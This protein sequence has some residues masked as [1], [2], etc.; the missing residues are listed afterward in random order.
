MSVKRVACALISALLCGCFSA[1]GAGEEAPD[2]SVS[3]TVTEPAPA[4]EAAVYLDGKNGNDEN[5][6]LTPELAVASVKKAFSLVEEGRTRV[7]VVGTP[8]AEM[9]VVLPKY[10]VEVTVT[11]VHNGVDYAKKNGAALRVTAMSLGGDTVFEN[12]TLVPGTE[13]ARICC[14]FNDLTVGEGVTVRNAGKRSVRIIGGYH[15]TDVALN[16]DSPMKANGV[17]Y[18]GDLD[19]TVNS[20]IWHS[21]VGGNYRAGQ[22]S[23]VGTFN[24]TLTVNIG[25]S[26]EFVSDGRADDV[27]A[28]AVSAGGANIHKGAVILN[29]SGGRFACP[30]YGMSK[31]GTYFNY[32][33]A[34]GKT[35]TDGLRYRKNVKYEADI[36]VNI[37]GG[38]FSDGNCS[39]I[40]AL[41]KAGDTAVHGNYT[42]NITGGNFGNNTSFSALGMLGESI[43]TGI[44]EGAEAKC[45]TSVNG[46]K[47]AEKAPVRIACVG[48]SITFGTCAKDSVKDGYTYPKDNA[49]Y[50]SVMQKL[51]GYDAVVGNFG[52]P[53]ANVTSSSYAKY[54]LSCSYNMLL[55]FE[56]DIII[57]ALGTN[58]ASVM[59]N[60]K[61]DF[62]NAYR[63][64]LQAMHKHYPEAEIIM[65]TALYRW[66]SAERTTQVEKYIIPVQKQMADE[67]DY[68]T[69]YDAFT[70]YKPYGTVAYY[71]DKLHPNNAGYE[72]LA[73]VMKKAADSLLE[74]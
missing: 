1:C 34:N 14:C 32:T 69:L 45:F 26:A 31:L 74:K 62:T 56:P 66:D 10:N 37:S 58:N 21:V 3:D 67:F 7:V 2:P 40:G 4:A 38:D 60:G 27:V 71:H 22:N 53:G 18:E 47:S 23:P 61:S 55:T 44:P 39:V 68:V 30:V 50:P 49:Y 41:Q 59:P 73:E 36:T 54:Y 52:Y 13:Q 70:E 48:D 24:G 63:T 12:I 33:S 9:E 19:I 43:A 16:G 15:V 72:K 46:K 29:I 6:G 20:G 8:T 5:S 28:D 64:M 65:T 17:S 25:G 11:S 51:Y 57:I 42:L 35:G